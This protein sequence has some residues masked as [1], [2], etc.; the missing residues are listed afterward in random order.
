MSVLQLILLTFKYT[1]SSMK[2]NWQQKNWP[3]FIYSGKALDEFER[4]FLV[5]SSKLMGATAIINEEEGR[6][7]T[8]DLMSEEALKS[9]KIEGEILDRDSVSSSLLRQLGFAPQYSDHR[10]NDKEKGIAALMVSNYE[11]FDQPLSHEMMFNWQSNIIVGSWRIQDIGKYRTSEEPMQ[12]VSGYEGHYNV[13]FEAPPA[14]HVQKEMD[15]FIA[16]YNDSS[17]QGAHPMSPLVRA[18]IAHIYFVSIHPFEDGNGRIGRALSEK[19]LAQSI[20]RPA[21][22]ALSHAI[23]KNRKE[24]YKQLEQNNKELTI[25]LWMSYFSKTILEAVHHA[26]KLVRFTVNKTRF[27]DQMQQQTNERQAKVLSRMV[28]AGMDGFVGGMS[29]KK[30]MQMTGAIERTAIRDIQALEK[31]GAFTK[32]GKGRGVRYWLSLGVEFETEK[33]KFLKEQKV[34]HN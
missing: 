13:H 6:K 5:E 4:V 26:Q 17:P 15:T 10:A 23:E 31:L 25:D 18:S 20:G 21:L 22:V 14:S 34:N 3:D 29:V 32:T 8:I 12:V 27:F 11:A 16:W 9:S 28:A 19:V 30:Y 2:W 24:Y 7:F 1:V 33:N